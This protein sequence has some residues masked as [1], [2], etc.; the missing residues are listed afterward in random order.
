[1]PRYVNVLVQLAFT[2]HVCQ[3]KTAISAVAS[4]ATQENTA[5]RESTSVCKERNPCQQGA[6]V[7]LYD[8]YYCECGLGWTG[9]FCEVQEDLCNVSN[10][11]LNG[12]KCRGE[13]PGKILCECRDDY[14]G[15]MCEEKIEYCTLKPCFNNGSCKELN[16]K[17]YK[18]YCEEGYAG[19]NC[20]ITIDLCANWT[21]ENN[22]TCF[23]NDSRPFCHCLPEFTGERCET[24]VS[25]SGNFVMDFC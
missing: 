16:S 25:V 10:N 2:A 3:L 14:R 5:R 21:C 4:Q 1:M 12:G 15:E 23:V 8:G 22:G 20:E 13:Y 17:G 18:C 24:H 19:A 6:C 7:D 9:T 11:C